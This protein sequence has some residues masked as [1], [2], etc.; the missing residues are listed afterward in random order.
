MIFA[1]SLFLYRRILAENLP[2][3]KEKNGQIFESRPPQARACKP[4]HF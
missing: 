1:A 2:P 4:L 3:V